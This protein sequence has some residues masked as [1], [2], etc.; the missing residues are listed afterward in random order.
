MSLKVFPSLSFSARDGRELVLNLPFS[1]ILQWDHLGLQ[2][3][4]SGG[5]ISTLIPLWSE[6]MF[7]IISNI[8]GL[9][10]FVLKPS[11]WSILACVLWVLEKNVYSAV[12]WWSILSMSHRSYWLIAFLSSSISLLIFCLV[13]LLSIAKSGMLNSPSL[14]WI[15][16]SL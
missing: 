13:V 8:F 2:N 16:F 4:F 11:I 7:S 12:V 5:L 10:M 9:L 3:S 15:Y 1:R 14:I 6:N